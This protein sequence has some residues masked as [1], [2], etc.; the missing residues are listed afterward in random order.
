MSHY[1]LLWVLDELLVHLL[2][3]E[4]HV[5]GIDVEEGGQRDGDFVQPLLVVRLVRVQTLKLL[6]VS[7]LNIFF[8]V[9][10]I[11][12]NIYFQGKIYLNS[13]ATIS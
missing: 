4:C 5:S 12:S 7:N 11:F 6:V 2:V 13:K 3:E 8:F 10:N 1:Y 9:K